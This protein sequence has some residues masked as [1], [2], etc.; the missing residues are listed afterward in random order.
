MHLMV[1]EHVADILTKKTFNAFPELL[2]TVDVL[3]L[4]SPGA[5]WR[6]GR[7]R[8]ERLYLFLHAKIPRNV[9]DQILDDRKGLHWLDCHRFFQRQ[10]VEARHAHELRQTVDFRRARPALSS[11]TIPSTG[12]IAR[13]RGL[14]LNYRIQHNHAFG[15]FGRVIAK[16]AALRIATPDFEGGGHWLKR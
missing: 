8:L 11:L 15:D 12:Q 14:N 7:S 9:C 2:H 1:A 4:H 6:V 5:V 10:F 13:L 16:F 3:L